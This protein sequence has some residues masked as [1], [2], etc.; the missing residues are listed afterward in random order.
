MSL[1]KCQNCGCESALVTPAPCPTPGGCPS[2]QVCAEVFD[3]KCIIYNGDNIICN[4]NTIV[5]SNTNV[6]T[7]LNQIADQFCPTTKVF[8][9][10]IS[11]SGIS[12]PTITILENQLGITFTPSYLG[13]AGQFLLT[14]PI[15]SLPV[16]KTYYNFQMKSGVSTAA[17]TAFLNPDNFS[18]FA[19]APATGTGLNGALINAPFEIVLYP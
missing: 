15:N 18:L 19:Y 14:F 16:N 8:R 1:N 11:Q 13:V 5:T 10:L 7:A 3:A 17:L 12:A 2:P 6:D 9:G 4:G